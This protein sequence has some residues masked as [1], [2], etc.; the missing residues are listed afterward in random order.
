[1]AIVML[2]QECGPRVSLMTCH[3]LPPRVLICASHHDRMEI[4][5][6]NHIRT[7]GATIAMKYKAMS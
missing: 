6:M 2:S 5:L 1:M 4:K 7:I 3:C